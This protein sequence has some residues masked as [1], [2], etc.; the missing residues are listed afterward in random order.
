MKGGWT[1][2]EP[3]GVK[4]EM[5]RNGAFNADQGLTLTKTQAHTVLGFHVSDFQ[6]MMANT[7]GKTVLIV[8]DGKPMTRISELGHPE[9]PI[10]GEMTNA[11]KRGMNVSISIVSEQGNTHRLNA[12]LIGFT[13]AYECVQPF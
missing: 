1:C 3:V 2:H 10:D 11:L 7:I 5:G 13:R 4:K 12:H 6:W 8:D 9:I